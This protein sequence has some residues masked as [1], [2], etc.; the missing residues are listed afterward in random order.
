M[1]DEVRDVT[2]FDPAT[3]AA[4]RFAAQRA[5]DYRAALVVLDAYE[6][7]GAAWCDEGMFAA[8][9]AVA[10][11]AIA[12]RA[13]LGAYMD[14]DLGSPDEAALGAAVTDAERALDGATDALVALAAGGAS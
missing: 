14:T 2:R 11:A 6:A 9:F 12:Y 5:D 10:R 7:A 4:A 3:E 1:N 8:V 13:A